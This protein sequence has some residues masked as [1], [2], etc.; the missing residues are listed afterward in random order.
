MK[1]KKKSTLLKNFILHFIC[2]LLWIG[3][4]HIASTS[5][6]N[7]IF[8]PSPKSVFNAFWYN[9]LPSKTFYKSLINSL[10]NIG[11]GFLIG[12]LL[13]IS[14]AIISSISNIIK[15]FISLP[16]KVVKSVPVASFVILSLLWFD[17]SKLAIF[18][19]ALIVLPTIY[20]NTLAGINQTNDKLL[21]MAKL[22]HISFPKRLFHIYIPCTIPYILSACSL[23]VG[24]AWK[25]GVAAEI[26][27]LAKESIGNELYKAKL[28]FMTPELFA[29]TIVIVLLS[30]L[31]EAFV[32]FIVKLITVN[33]FK[34]A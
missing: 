15:A 24:M 8:L 22:F 28:Y 26:I 19:P 23:A 14:F 31:C 16:I 2:L 1:T 29:W 7:E 6:N 33:S 10:Y 18:V 13:G 34:N 5:I 21:D 30:I 20:I 17:A 32:K 11:L 9:L 27:G 4:W 3:I 25:A 12:A